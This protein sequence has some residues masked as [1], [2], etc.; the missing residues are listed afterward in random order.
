MVIAMLD[1]QVG[2]KMRGPL[3]AARIALRQ[4]SLS[5]SAL[6]FTTD[7]PWPHESASLSTISKGNNIS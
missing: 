5:V 6:S 7:L 4:A 2:R 3:A 1:M